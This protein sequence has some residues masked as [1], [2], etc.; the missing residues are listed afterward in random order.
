MFVSTSKGIKY[1][2]NLSYVNRQTFCVFDDTQT[3]LLSSFYVAI[4]TSI[5]SSYPFLTYLP[6]KAV[7]V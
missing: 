1:I 5:L 4:L 6:V 2:D 7:K 3:N